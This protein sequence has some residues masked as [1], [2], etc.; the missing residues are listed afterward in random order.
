MRRFVGLA[1]LVC[2]VPLSLPAQATIAGTWLTEF[3]TQVRIVN[4]VESSAGRDMRASS[5]S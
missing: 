4:G 3:D 2:A 1:C 5:C